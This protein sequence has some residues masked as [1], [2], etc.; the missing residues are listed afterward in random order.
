M[1]EGPC[2]NC[3]GRGYIVMQEWEEE[4][5]TKCPRCG[6]PMEFL[7]QGGFPSGY[8]RMGLPEVSDDPGISGNVSFGR[9]R[10]VE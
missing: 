8:P 5:V 1:A 7:Q 6:Q 2:E 10:V 9:H 3:E 4:P